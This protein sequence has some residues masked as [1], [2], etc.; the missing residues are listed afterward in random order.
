MIAAAAAAWAVAKRVAGWQGF[1]YLVGI[2]LVAAIVFGIDSNGYRRGVRDE[3]QAEADR[4]AAAARQ[5][6][7]VEKK[8]DQA[9]AKVEATVSGKVAGLR[10]TGRVIIEKVP[11]YVTAKADRNCPVPA[12]FVSLHDA[13]VEGRLPGVAERAADPDAVSGLALS[14][15]SRVIA[16]NTTTCLGWREVAAGWQ[17]WYRQ[18]SII[19]GRPPAPGQE[20]VSAPAR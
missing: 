19:H 14:D 11:V 3:Q 16:A 8:A 9:T 2:L 5:V 17:D 10:E 15:V 13:G 4:R 6:A 12:G 18:Q 1:P 20:P 7:K